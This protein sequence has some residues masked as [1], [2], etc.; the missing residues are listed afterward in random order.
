MLRM[1]LRVTFNTVARVVVTPTT[2][3]LVLLLLHNC[4]FA[5]VI[6]T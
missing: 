1:L 5:F 4:D 2:V 6:V 3:K